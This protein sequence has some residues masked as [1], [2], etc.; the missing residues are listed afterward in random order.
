LWLAPIATIENL[1]AT[2]TLAR[3]H[4]PGMAIAELDLPHRPASGVCP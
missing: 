3:N 4:D 1:Q 2:L